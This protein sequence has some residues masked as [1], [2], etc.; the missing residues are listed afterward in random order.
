MH[1]LHPFLSR[2]LLAL[3]VAAPALSLSAAEAPVRQ[4]PRPPNLLVIL[5]DD[6]GFSDLGCYGSEIA[7]PNLDRLAA[8]GLRFT[9]FYNTARCWPTRCAFMTGY[10]PQQIHADPPR[11]LFPEWTRT[12]PHHLKPAG[13]RCYHSGKW[14]VNGAPRALADAGFD[15]SYRLEDHDRNF[16]PRNLIEDDRKLPPVP[17]GTGYYT[18]TAF[19]DHTIRC[20][21]DHAARHAERPFFAFLAFTTPHFPLHAPPEDIAFYRERYQAGWDVLRAE[22]HQR[23]RQLG[24]AQS[25][26]APPEPHIRAPSGKPGVESRISP[27]EIAYA[28]PWSGLTESQQRF[29]ASK[30]AVHAAMVHRLD[31]EIGRVLTQLKAMNALDN[32]LILFFSDNGASAEIL[33][34]GDGHDPSAAPGSARSYLCLGPGW[35]TAAN[36]PFRRHKIWV[37]EGGISTPLIAHWPNGIAA[38]GELRHAPGHVVDLLPTLLDAAGLPS[39]TRANAPA[40]APTPPPLPGRSLVPAFARDPASPPAFLFFHHANNRALRAGDWKIVSAHDA[41][42]AW[43]LYNLAR[44]RG[45]TTNLAASEAD[46]VRSMA[47]RWQALED[48]FRRDAGPVRTQPPLRPPGRKSS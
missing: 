16:N 13:Y 19:A 28:L 2:V 18:A 35:S 12:L 15:H 25:P 7:T 23:L 26:L 22:R 42:D 41:G 4:P 45:E 3:A 36:T 38:R 37:H 40:N 24:I 9:Q 33:V 39:A 32:T 29:Q 8:D 30:M 34:R 48:Q 46:R 14:H 10:Y 6:M 17:P 44:D 1:R 31:R 43:E 20:L 21:K 11:G 5:A 47:A 27:D